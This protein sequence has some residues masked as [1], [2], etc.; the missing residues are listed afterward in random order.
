MGVGHVDVIA[1]VCYNGPFAIV[2]DDG[3]VD[4]FAVDVV[5]V[6]VHVSVDSECYS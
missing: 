6:V 5:I 1:A 3:S 4:E 2:N